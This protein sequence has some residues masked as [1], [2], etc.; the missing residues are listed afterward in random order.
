MV[1]NKSVEGNWDIVNKNGHN[2]FHNGKPGNFNSL[3]EDIWLILWCCY[4]EI[5]W[6]WESVP[7][8]VLWLLTIVRYLC[9]AW[10]MTLK[11]LD[12]TSG[13]CR[14]NM[15]ELSEELQQSS[16]IIRMR[17]YLLKE[18]LQIQYT[19]TSFCICLWWSNYLPKFYYISP[20]L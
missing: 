9:T 10:G 4:L 14:R 5:D 8:K 15:S 20:L 17:S 7:K 11:H 2:T 13:Y 16:I 19:E 3:I 18:Q 1:K 6:K 12:H